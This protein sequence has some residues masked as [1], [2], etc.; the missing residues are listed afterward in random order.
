MRANFIQIDPNDNVAT[1]LLDAKKGSVYTVCDLE[2][3]KVCSL[4]AAEDIPFCNKI[5]LANIG[6]SEYLIKY[7]A[8]IG[9][10]R[11]AIEKGCLIQVHNTGSLSV[12]IPQSARLEIMRIMGL[13]EMR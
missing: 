7:G 3:K 9:Y 10:A 6:K 5:A 11:C 4:E 1:A 12:E 13:K 8:P 2:G